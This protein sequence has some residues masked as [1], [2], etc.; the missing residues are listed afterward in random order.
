M[1]LLEDTLII[2]EL[3]TFERKHKL[4][5]MSNCSTFNYNTMD[6]EDFNLN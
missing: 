3:G 1:C 4:G 6:I 5:S 2:H